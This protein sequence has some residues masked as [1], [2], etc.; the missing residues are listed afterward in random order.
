LDRLFVYGSLKANG[1]AH[2]L[3]QGAEREAD[4]VLEAAELIEVSGYPM[5]RSGSAEVRGEVYRIPVS[6]WP[7]L[8]DWEDAPEVYQRRKRELKDGRSVWVYEAP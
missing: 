5:L 1:I 2:N 6:R 4:G 8:D 7:A 3:I